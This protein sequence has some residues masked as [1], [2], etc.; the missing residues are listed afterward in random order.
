MNSGEKEEKTL[1]SSNLHSH[2]GRLWKKSLTHIHTKTQEIYSML[3][4]VIW[5]GNRDFEE[6]SSFKQGD[7]GMCP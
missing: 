4:A 5:L 2:K 1:L 7:Q 6:E 3:L